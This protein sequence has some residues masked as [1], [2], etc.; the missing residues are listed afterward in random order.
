MGTGVGALVSIINLVFWVY[1]LVV[2]ARVLLSW[3]RSP[4]VGSP[5]TP[6]WNFIYAATEPLLIP[7]RKALS[8]L[9]KGTPLDF[10]PL[11][12]LL[13]L[14]VVRGIIIMVV[15]GPGRLF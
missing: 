3:I 1:G 14:Q 5:L 15:A 2:I 9:M 11:V 8:G 6:L 10:S 7:I 13:L 4:A 12:L